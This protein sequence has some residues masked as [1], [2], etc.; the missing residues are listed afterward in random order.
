MMLKRR[1][2]ILMFSVFIVG[3]NLLT[4][5]SPEFNKNVSTAVSEQLTASPIVIVSS[6]ETAAPGEISQ[7][8]S[9]E[10]IQPSE[11]EI[12]T[13]TIT[14]T[15]TLSPDDPRLKLGA[16]TWK[17]DFNKANNNFYQYENDQTRFMYDSGTLALTGKNPNGWLGWSLT[18][19]KPRDFYL[20]ATFKVETCSGLDRYG[21]VYRAPDFNN[22]YFFAF[23]C[24]GQYS[25]RI[26]NQKG[27]L[28][29]W[30]PNPAILSGSNQVNRI[31]ILAL[32]DRYAFY[33]NGKLLQETKESTFL[34]AGMF[35][36]FVAST[37][38][39]NF[40][41]RMDEIAF[42]NK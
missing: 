20:E 40:T 32:G 10:S 8:P 26:Y 39:S 19:P 37:N 6:S 23:S 38:T 13:P 9:L 24:D 22:G 14:S 1:F 41:V 4:S 34:D 18:Y 28:I 21:L 30:T 31:G 42:W 35:G 2:L 16:P 29:D 33:A 15:P 17:E 7:T 11:T 27:S 25:L 3:C 12:S 5:T 36:G